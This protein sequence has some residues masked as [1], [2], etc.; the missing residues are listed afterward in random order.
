MKLCPTDRVMSA[1]LVFPLFLSCC[2][3]SLKVVEETRR[4]EESRGKKK[5]VCFHTVSRFDA[6]AIQCLY[7]SDASTVII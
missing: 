2:T 1:L 7:L 6:T 5:D 4:E 3:Q